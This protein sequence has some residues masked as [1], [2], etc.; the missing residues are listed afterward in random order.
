MRTTIPLLFWLLTANLA[1]AMEIDHHAST[2][3]FTVE[4]GGNIKE[5]SF[6]G[7]HATLE[8]RD[9]L[10]AGFDVVVQ[11]ASAS[12]GNALFDSV[13][14]SPDWLDAAAHPE[15]RFVVDRIESSG[16]GSHTA[17]GMLTLNGHERP[18][19]VTIREVGPLDDRTF[20][21]FAQLSRLDFGMTDITAPVAETVAITGR[22]HL[23]D[24]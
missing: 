17:T 23:L 16:R 14:L 10:I 19:A 21:V 2:L 20:E 18:L 11:I 22:I 9:D 6:A 15:A 8:T 4:I 12:L 5:A 3:G 13:M 1:Q 7:W 24:Q